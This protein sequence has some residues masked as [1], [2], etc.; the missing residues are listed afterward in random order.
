VIPAL[1]QILCCYVDTVM[2]H[3]ASVAELAEA[4]L[5]VRESNTELD[6]NWQR[7]NIALDGLNFRLGSDTTQAIDIIRKEIYLAAFLATQSPDIAAYTSDDFGLF[8]M[9]SAVGFRDPWLEALYSS[10]KRTGFTT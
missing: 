9:A 1:D 8:A 7:V 4:L 3:L 5:E 2:P 6:A 10:Y